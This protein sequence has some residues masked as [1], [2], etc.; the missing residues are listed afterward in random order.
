MVNK[1]SFFSLL[2]FFIY[3][4][5]TGWSSIT[6]LIVILNA[7]LVLL[8]TALQCKEVIRNVRK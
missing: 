3:A 2:F 7:A 1:I 6:K 8:Q 5:C 4:V